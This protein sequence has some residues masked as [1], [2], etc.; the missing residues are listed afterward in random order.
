MRRST[1]VAVAGAAGVLVAAGQLPQIPH[2]LAGLGDAAREVSAGIAAGRGAVV[3]L[4]RGPLPFMLV[5]ASIG[6]AV[7][8]TLRRA[9]RPVD[10]RT[11]VLRM[12]SLGRPIADIARTAR[13]PLDTVRMMLAPAARSPR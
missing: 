4:L 9:L 3:G 1:L 2:V 10:A 5:G 8:H 7:G 13:L 6:I 12:A 11:R